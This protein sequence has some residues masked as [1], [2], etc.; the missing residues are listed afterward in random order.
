MELTVQEK[1]AHDTAPTLPGNKG[2]F[3]ESVA[4]ETYQPLRATQR[5]PVK[6]VVPRPTPCRRKESGSQTA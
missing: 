5:V 1:Q 3:G 2:Q 6:P 4:T